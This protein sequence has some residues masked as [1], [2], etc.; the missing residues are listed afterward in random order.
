MLVLSRKPGEAITVGPLFSL[1][2]RCLVAPSLCPPET[3]PSGGAA[4][5]APRQ[6][7]PPP[8]FA[9]GAPVDPGLRLRFPGS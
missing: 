3:E 7:D 6:V 2:G 5:P 9:P 1:G 8:R 4:G